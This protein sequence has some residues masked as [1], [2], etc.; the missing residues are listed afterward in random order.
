[1]IKQ[2]MAWMTVGVVALAQV[3]LGGGV[4]SVYAVLEENPA[5]SVCTDDGYKFQLDA[6]DS[7]KKKL[8]LPAGEYKITVSG[9]FKYAP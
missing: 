3:N 1:M 9:E 8:N 6:S 5:E 4:G 7:G 2:I